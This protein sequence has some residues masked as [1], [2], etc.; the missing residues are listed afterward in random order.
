[1]T[2]GHWTDKATAATQALQHALEQ[3]HAALTWAART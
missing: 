2:V 3:A 1:V